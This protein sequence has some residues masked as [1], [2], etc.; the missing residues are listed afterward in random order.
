[1]NRSCEFRPLR[2]VLLAAL[3]AVSTANAASLPGFR[4]ELLG[5]TSG[6][7]TSLAVA[8]DGT[9]YY[10]TIS[11][12]IVRF[13]NGVNTVVAHLPTEPAGDAGLLG[14]A[15]LDD[16]TAVVHYTTPG[17]TEE[18]ISRVD[19][20]TGEKSIV[21]GFVCDI[22]LPGRS[23]SPE[24]HGGNPIVTD[25]GFIYFGIGD[26]G[27]GA[28]AALPEW[29][30]GKIFRIAPDGAM[31]QIARGFRNPFDMAWDPEHRR[32]VVCD[33]GTM[34]D[35]EINIVDGVAGFYGWPFTAGNGPPIEGAIPPIYTF[36]E[37][38]AP[39]G[40]IRLNGA[41][42][43]LKRGYLI[44]AFVTKAIYYVLD[45]DVRP[46]PDPIALLKGDT[47]SIVD[48]AQTSTGDIVFTTGSAIYRLDPPLRGDCNG[49]G[50]VTLADLDALR[51]EV[52]DGTVATV[53]APA[54]W[55]CD[56]NGDG[57]ISGADLITIAQMIG[58]RL[59][60]VRVR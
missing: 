30:G 44:G 10:S 34:A 60:A 37:V 7:V 39:T 28:I 52:A 48:I 33:N 53:A 43:F 32:I 1:M 22:T 20:I 24:H 17:Q 27:G 15:L 47:G 38:V 42:S 56:A 35:D 9:L 45:I 18:I 36:P 8:S 19:L 11:G 31:T 58:L 57:L 5:P 16:R 41:N 13:D 23:V 46:L 54:S 2:S 50:R 29:N 26:F 21:Q 12:D 6:F 14:L 40:M 3:L 51:R 49:D 59:R 55:G 25:D 4:A